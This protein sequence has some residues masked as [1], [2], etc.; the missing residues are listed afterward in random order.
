MEKWIARG[1]PSHD[2]WDW[3][4]PVDELFSCRIDERPGFSRRLASL[5]F[6]SSAAVRMRQVGSKVAEATDSGM[7]VVGAKMEEA[8]PTIGR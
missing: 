8:A 2:R 7:K 5:L 4:A 3:K 6:D 1:F